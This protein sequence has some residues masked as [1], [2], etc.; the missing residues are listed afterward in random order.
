MSTYIQLKQ[1]VW[2]RD[3]FICFYCGENLAGEYQNRG[4]RRCRLTVD[5]KIP[6][7]KGGLTN[8][9]NLV[10]CCFECNQKKDIRER[11]VIYKRPLTK[12]K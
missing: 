2:R 11:T 6:R 12:T 8:M 7:H 1:R 4:T 10:T 3:R 9:E 5:H